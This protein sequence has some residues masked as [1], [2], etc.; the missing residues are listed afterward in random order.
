MEFA[1]PTETVAQVAQRMSTMGIS[2]MPIRAT[3]ETPTMMIHESDLL[4]FLLKDNNPSATVLQAAAPLEAT[5]RVDD[6]ISALEP[7]LEQNNVA[8]VT[9]ANSEI[10]GIVSK[11]DVVKYLASKIE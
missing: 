3:S 9:N 11:I 10:I 2:Q 1:E 8:V 6:D 4:H 7:L 5:V